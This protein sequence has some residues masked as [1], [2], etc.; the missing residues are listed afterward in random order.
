MPADEVQI[1][2]VDD[3][4]REAEFCE[5]PYQHYRSNPFWV[6][7]LRRQ[8]QE[9]WSERHNPS[10]RH[11]RWQRYLARL[12]G[13]IVGRIAAI[14]DAR[15]NEL[16][17]AEAGFF[18]FFES[19]DD[20]DV[21]HALLAE[22]ELF[23]LQSG[24]R[25][26]LGPVNL[27]THDEV[28]LL[29]GG[30]D[31]PPTFLSPYNPRF[32]PA[33]LQSCGYTGFQDYHAFRGDPAFRPAPEVEQLVRAIASRASRHQVSIRHLDPA[34]WESEKHSI[35]EIYNASF[36]DVWGFVPLHWEEFNARAESFKPFYRPELILIAEK[37]DRPVGF[38]V[39][40]PDI[41][42]LLAKLNGRLGILGWIRLA[43][44]IRRIRKARL[45]LL[46]VHPSF[47]GSGIAA[48][49]SDASRRAAAKLEIPECELSLV[50]H[51]NRGVRRLIDAFGAPPTKTFR[52]YE[53]QL[54]S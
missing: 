12:E 14:I 7:P 22:A 41:N 30:F 27:T 10:L 37:Q 3:P 51:G 49:L 36:T 53:R 33:L 2:L 9:T 8:S 39:L 11:R 34:R 20:H 52:L 16:W 38:S 15:F 28:G 18:G 23:L 31:L 40:L 32:Y 19:V 6:P 50:S 4:R 1:E 24:M 5:F 25:R 43:L 54:A 48:L 46:G 13:R 42:E 45:L 44:G 29:V 26:S 21:A 47:V 35:F 17:D